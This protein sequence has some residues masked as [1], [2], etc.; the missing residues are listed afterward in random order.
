MF[1]FTSERK[2]AKALRQINDLSISLSTERNFDRL[3]EMILEAAIDISNADNGIF[4]TLNQDD[5]LEYTIMKSSS[6]NINYGGPS[7]EKVPFSPIKLYNA[8]GEANFDRVSTSTAIKRTSINIENVYK[9]STYNFTGTKAFDT[10]HSYRSQSILAVPVIYKNSKPLG[11]LHLTNAKGAWGRTTYFSTEV[12]SWI[13]SLASIAAV[14]I[15]KQRLFL[16]EERFIDGIVKMLAFAI[17]K[18]SPHTSTHCQAIPA[19]VEMITDAACSEKEGYFA[20][21]DLNEIERHELKVAAWLHDCG[22]LTTPP[23]ILEKS[24]KLETIYDRIEL[25]ETRLEILVRDNE[26]A[27]LKQ[28]ITQ[29][30][31]TNTLSYLNKNLIFINKLNKGSEFVDDS[32]MTKLDKIAAFTWQKKLGNDNKELPFFS[33]NE[34]QNLSIRKGTLTEEERKIVNYHI[35]I[36]IEMLES[37]PFP[38]HL[39]NV[40]EY[41]GGHHER[42]DGSGFPKGLTRDEMSIPARIMAVADIFEALTSKD[43]PYKKPKTLSQALTIMA[44]MKRTNHI[45]PD[46]FDLFLKRK[47]YLQY[48]KK[49]LLTSQIDDINEEEILELSNG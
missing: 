39:K 43:R 25:I 15:E 3:L 6:L 40:P 24:T 48:A 26:I 23:H 37:L 13:E 9:S 21:F 2:K 47:V 4:Y 30:T 18:K 20:S 16:Q 45:D 19:I 42:M 27:Y 35:D 49:H 8:N 10:M 11:V 46:I 12:Q 33:E 5:T 22:K 38:E 7:G 28:E 41:A 29:D 1:F 44:H 31:Y 34:Y 17:D 32:K 14:T 36:T